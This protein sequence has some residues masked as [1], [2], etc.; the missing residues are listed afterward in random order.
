MNVSRSEWT[1]LLV[2]DDAI[3]RDWLRLVLQDE[4]RVVGEASSAESAFDLIARRRPALLLVDYRLPRVRGTELL[5]QLRRSGVTVPAV[6]MTANPERGLNELAREAGAQGTVLK[7]GSRQDLL[8]ALRAVT[9]GRSSFDSRHPRRDPGEAALSPREKEILRLVA[10]GRTN[11]EIAAHLS[12]GVET[13]KTTLS[14]ACTKL[15][16]RRRAQAVATAQAQDL[17]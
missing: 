17:L 11:T 5:K 10:S 9:A 6:V 14:R 8:D 4:F 13:V 1:V 7:S 15:G 12:V 16:V 3:V 2:E